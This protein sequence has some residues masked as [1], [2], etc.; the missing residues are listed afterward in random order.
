MLGRHCRSGLSLVVVSGHCPALQYP[1]FSCCRAQALDSWASVAAAHGL[2]RDVG[3]GC[4]MACGIFPDQGSN[5]CPLHWQADSY[6]PY[7]LGSPDHFSIR[8]SVLSLRC[9]SS[10]LYILDISVSSD[11]FIAN[12]FS[13]SV[14]GL[15][16]L[17]F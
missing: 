7:H 15:F 2:S 8:L 3:L 1:G 9:S 6:P 16:I 4:P 14:Q 13:H 12:I 10:S 11:L 17:F 5:R